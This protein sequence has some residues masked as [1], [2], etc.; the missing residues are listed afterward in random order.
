M[1][2]LV[3]LPLLLFAFACAPVIAQADPV[4]LTPTTVMLH[5]EEL[6]VIANGVY[7]RTV[8][9]SDGPYTRGQLSGGQ[10]VPAGARFNFSAT[11]SHNI[12][13]SGVYVINDT[14]YQLIPMNASVTFN[15]GS[16]TLPTDGSN[17]DVVMPFT[18]TRGSVTGGR[19]FNDYSTLFSYTLSPGLTGIMRASFIRT[20]NGF[21]ELRNVNWDI[22][23]TPEP[24][25]FVLLGT[26]LAGLAAAARRRRKARR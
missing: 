4:M 5:G 13:G 1:K 24:A 15:A 17:M 21:Y 2:R 11:F 22:N 26:G 20:P 18:M 8:Y 12:G 14:V 25:T 19:S 9:L 23:G 16:V 10:L 7:I 6:F 3:R